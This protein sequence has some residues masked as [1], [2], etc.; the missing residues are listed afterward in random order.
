MSVP[1]LLD[2]LLAEGMTF[3]LSKHNGKEYAVWF[4]NSGSITS[5]D[6]DL[7]ER[8]NAEIVRLLKERGEA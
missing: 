8:H 2:R 1:K 6:I 3:R 4:H 5:K 7:V